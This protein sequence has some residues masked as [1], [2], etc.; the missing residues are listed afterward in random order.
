MLAIGGF[1]GSDPSPTLA[2]FK[3]LVAADGSTTSSPE[4]TGGRGGPGGMGG[5]GGGAS[6]A[7]SAITSWVEETFTQTTLDGVTVYDLTAGRTTG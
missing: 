2:E 7:S 6:G 5:P 3:D 1:N 4:A